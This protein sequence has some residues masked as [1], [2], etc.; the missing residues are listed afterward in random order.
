MG[1]VERFGDSIYFC[2][3][4]LLPLKLS[5]SPTTQNQPI[6]Q[7]VSL[8]SKNVS[9]CVLEKPKDFWF[10][11]SVE[12]IIAKLSLNPTSSTLTEFSTRPTRRSALGS[13]LN[14]LGYHRKAYSST[15]QIN[16]DL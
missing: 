9:E 14:Q 7:N 5:P 13:G 2:T 10:K 15:W 16:T 3:L 8:Y 11:K 4:S 1:W 6:P 12:K